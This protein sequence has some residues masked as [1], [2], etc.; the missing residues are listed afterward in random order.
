VEVL[1]AIG[2]AWLVLSV[3]L[4]L[5][6]GRAIRRA[7]TAELAPRRSTDSGE[8]DEDARPED[9]DTDRRAA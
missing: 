1:L 4:G 3:V 2:A 6:L 8:H 5:T 7:D 9:P